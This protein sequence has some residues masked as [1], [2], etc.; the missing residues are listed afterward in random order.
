MNAF[1]AVV[2]SGGATPSLSRLLLLASGEAPKAEIMKAGLLPAEAIR[3][4]PSFGRK[5]NSGP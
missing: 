5:G 4:L 3:F 1:T 2:G